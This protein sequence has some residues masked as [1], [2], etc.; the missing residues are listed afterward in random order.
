MNTTL[1][2]LLRV[3]FP[4]LALVLLTSAPAVAQELPYRP[5]PFR[6]GESVHSRP[7]IA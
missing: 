1:N 2:P 6:R 5:A 7:P 3:A 4:A